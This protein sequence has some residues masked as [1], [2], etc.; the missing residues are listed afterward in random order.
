MSWARLERAEPEMAALARQEFD[1]AH[2]AL[3]GTIRRDGTPRISSVDPTI[4]DGVLYLGMMWRSR[5]AL[6]LLRD[7]RVLLR[8]AV[9][10]NKGDEVE[11]SLRGRVREIREPDERGRFIAAATTPWR[12][13]RF[14]L[15]AMEV[16][17][18]ALVRYGNGLQSVNVWPGGP[19]FERPYG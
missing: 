4:L 11:V 9:A 7:P 1:K 8:N 5:K 14:H 2:V 15:F 12:E 10:T 18:A 16:E 3:I 6:D 17:S 19:E 13:P